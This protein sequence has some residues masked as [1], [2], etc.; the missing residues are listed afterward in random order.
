[1]KPLAIGGLA[2]HV[3][4]LACLP[5]T[6]TVSKAIQLV[7]G[8]TSKWI[9]DTFPQLR[10]FQWQEGYA[11]FSVS[12]SQIQETIAYIKSQE[13]HHHRKSFKEEYLALLRKHDIDYD[14]RYLWK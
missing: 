4:I 2:D 5:T 6:I 3:H 1:M 12:V 13:K 11:E 7:K 14:E 9:N 8:G 10:R